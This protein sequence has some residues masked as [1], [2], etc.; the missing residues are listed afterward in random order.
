[1]PFPTLPSGYKPDS[2]EFVESVENPA[3]R[4]ELEGGYVASRPKHTRTPRKSWDIKY[5]G[6]TNADKSAIETHWNSVRGGSLIFD[7]VNP[8]SGVTWSVRYNDAPKWEYVGM[9]N[10]QLWDCSFKLEQA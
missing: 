10:T 1:M 7:W 5:R 9:G 8:Q 4:T 2:Q 3:L 6:L